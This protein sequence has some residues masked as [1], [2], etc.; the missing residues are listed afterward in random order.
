MAAIWAQVSIGRRLIVCFGF[1]VCLLVGVLFLTGQAI[2]AL[3]KQNRHIANV[4]LPQ[5]I[6]VASLKGYAE[7][8]AIHLLMLLFTQE[9]DQR[10]DLYAAI[11]H[12]NKRIDEVIHAF[13]Q[14][15]NML[16]GDQFNGVRNQYQDAFNE[17]VELLE[18]DVDAA[19][20]QF[21]SE[22]KPALVAFLHEVELIA[23]QKSQS[24]VREQLITAK[25]A[26]TARFWSLL[27]GGL[28][29]LLA[30][31]LMWLVVKSITAPLKEAVFIAHRIAGGDLSSPPMPVGRDEIASLMLAFCEMCKGLQK[32]M[33][34]IQE[35]A[36]SVKSIACDLVQ[37]VAV[38]HAGSSDQS[39]AVERVSDYVAVFSRDT[40][41][42]SAIS[43]SAKAQSKEAHDLAVNGKSLINRVSKEFD[44]ISQTITHSA[45]AVTTLSESAAS[46]RVLVTT[47]REIAEQTNLLALNAA[48]EAARA[49]EAGRGFSVVADEVRGLANR[50]ELATTQINDVIDAMENETAAAVNQISKGCGELE[51]GVAMINQM[52][53]PLNALNINADKS[54]QSLEQLSD[55][56]ERQ[57]R[58]SNDIH[59]E[60]GYV[61]TKANDNVASAESVRQI[62][63]TLTSIS[64]ELDNVV[65]YFKV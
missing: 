46:V 35:N 39:Q 14:D 63:A 36:R 16:L 8:A 45:S 51:S 25:Q 44:K 48:I 4:E 18:F 9:R 32:Q 38:V 15:S 33:S 40:D 47:V 65:Q 17:T 57:S 53:S 29:V 23:T 60:V 19:T 31:L 58:V 10:V 28:G 43:S 59:S 55:V 22:T 11:D 2:Q 24:L 62:T 49:G 37:P 7:D 30:G 3:S 41:E 56:V 52:V 6:E 26:N 5:F 12:N 13:K 42:V 64:N 27:I 61:N 1:L 21:T 20:A 54:Y 50:T 34:L